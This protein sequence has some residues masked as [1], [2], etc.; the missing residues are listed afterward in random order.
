MFTEAYLGEIR[1][2]AGS[3]APDGWAFCDGQM[4]SVHEHSDL[5]GVIGNT[6]G[7]DGGNSFALPDLRGRAALCQGTGAGL[8]ERKLGESGGEAAV[9]L[10]EDQLP[11]HTH[12]AR[13]TISPAKNSSPAEGVWARSTGTDK[14]FP[15]LKTDTP[16]AH[17]HTAALESTGENQPHNN[18]QPYL[19]L[20]FIIAVEGEIPHRN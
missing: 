17:L 10:S 4:L 8:T 14:I 11:A 5:F 9:R 3:F 19:G 20:H 7:G 15:Y 1:I 6:Y 18:R 12:Q 16:D 2:F 13:A